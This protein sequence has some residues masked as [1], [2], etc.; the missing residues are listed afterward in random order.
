MSRSRSSS[1]N[2]PHRVDTRGRW[3]APESSHG[4]VDRS[5]WS[6]T[7]L[8]GALGLLLILGLGKLAAD[9]VTASAAQDDIGGTAAPNQCEAS[10]L[11][12]VGDTGL[13]THGPDP[14]PP[15]I[16]AS[17]VPSPISGVGGDPPIDCEGDG[18]SGNRVQVLYVRRSSD[19]SRPDVRATVRSIAQQANQIYRDS[20]AETGGSRSIR[21][22]HDS[23]CRIT[24]AEVVLGTPDF[25]YGFS[26]VINELDSQGYDREDRK[27]MIFGEGGTSCGIGTH[28]QQDRRDPANINNFGPSYGLSVPHCWLA[29]VVAHEL[30]HNL[31][32]VQDSAPHSTALGHCVDEY[33][34]MCYADGDGQPMRYECPTAARDTTLF[35]CNHDDY[36]HTSPSSSNYLRNQWNSANNQ[37]LIGAVNQPGYPVPPNDAIGNAIRATARPF[38]DERPVYSA[39]IGGEDPGFFPGCSP[40]YSDQTVWYK[41]TPATGGRLVIDSSDSNYRTIVA[42]YEGTRTEADPV[43]CAV[44]YDVSD[45]AVVDFTADAGTT[46]YILVGSFYSQFG[47]NLK[48]RVTGPPEPPE[49][50]LS[51]DKSKYNG[52][53]EATVTGLKPNASVTLRWPREFEITSG[54]NDGQ[55]TSLLA[56][57]TADAN[58]RATFSFRTP[59]EPYGDYRVTARDASGGSASDTLRVIPRILLNETGGPTNTR[60]R[61]YFYG[62]AP[63]ERIEVRWHSGAT[64]G[65]SL[66]VIKTL[67]VA[68]NG[69]ASSI[70]TIPPSTGTGSHMVV[71]KVIG[72][73]R[74]ASTPFEVTVG[75]GSV[76]DAPATPTRT[77]TAEATA[78]VTPEVTPTETATATPVATETPEPTATSSPE[79]AP[80][81]TPTPEPTET[82]IPNGSPVAAAGDDQA[83]TDAD[84]SGDESV[85]LDGGGSTDPEGGP[86]TYSWSVDGEVVATE[87]TS[88]VTLPVGSTTVLLTVADEQGTTATDEVVIA[89]E[90]LPDDDP[91]TES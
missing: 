22:V 24:V 36:F 76:D 15:G 5:G 53:V 32:G 87:A 91:P 43:A 63:S 12:P 2:S 78:T 27:Y 4:P 3:T 33:D 86:L 40:Y 45:G 9:T 14:I 62:F 71:G 55:F 67:T 50:T 70:V 7:L 74:S 38:V 21:F 23:S 73:S 18:S 26:Y 58:G 47:A 28:Y 29:E 69:R 25:Y 89:V 75:G 82:P 41:T 37:F 88:A 66:Q 60:L 51:K 16:D 64:I 48:I 13:C 81:E 6:S 72:V 57:S 34:V 19:P 90:P 54:P 77:V 35:D 85:Q 49:L 56:S 59:L 46:Y 31:G 17:D 44:G 84:G 39:T 68:S 42:V 52:P 79:P 65:S 8:V 83:V 20:A 30:L 11:I 1:E 61:V 80:T 10:G